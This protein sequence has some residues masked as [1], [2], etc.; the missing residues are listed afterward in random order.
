MPADA[1]SNS[2]GLTAGAH[3]TVVGALDKNGKKVLNVIINR[4]SRSLNRFYPL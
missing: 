2:E 1:P 3:Y 4:S